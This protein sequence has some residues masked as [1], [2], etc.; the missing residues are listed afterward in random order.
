MNLHF[1]K[2]I[3]RIWKIHRNSFSYFTKLSLKNDSRKPYVEYINFFRVLFTFKF[4]NDLIKW[5]LDYE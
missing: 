3:L 4:D 1:E 2:C 5:I